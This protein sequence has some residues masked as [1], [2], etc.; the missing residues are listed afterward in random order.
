M[1]VPGF[2]SPRC[3]CG[4]DPQTVEHLFARCLDPK[5][6]AMRGLGLWT[7]GEVRAALRDAQKALQMARKLLKS[8]LLPEFRVVEAL[9]MRAEVEQRQDDEVRGR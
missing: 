7:D 9:R 3:P 5:S 8:G 2:E 4:E 1:N 6:H